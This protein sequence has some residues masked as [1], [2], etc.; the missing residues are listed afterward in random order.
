MV[1]PNLIKANTLPDIVNENGEVVE[2]GIDAGE[3]SPVTDSTPIIVSSQGKFKA[4][5]AFEEEK[6]LFARISNM[7]RK[8]AETEEEKDFKRRKLELEERK[9]AIEEANSKSLLKR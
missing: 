6:E 3:I 9:I 7:V 5:K 2:K 4:S 1:Q 8:P